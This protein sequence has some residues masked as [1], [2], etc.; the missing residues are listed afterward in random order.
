M[1]DDFLCVLE[2]TIGN[3]NA[4]GVLTF[5]KRFRKIIIPDKKQV[6]NTVDLA[7]L[8]FC[9]WLA[10]YLVFKIARCAGT[11]VMCIGD[12]NAEIE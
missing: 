7:L 12:R 9:D 2:N 5:G 11:I 6:D 8:Y 1:V 10:G 3:G 4:F